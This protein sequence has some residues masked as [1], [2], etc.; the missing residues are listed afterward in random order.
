MTERAAVTVNAHIKFRN[1]QV[2]PGVAKQSIA[3]SR[4]VDC[5]RFLVFIKIYLPPQ[6]DQ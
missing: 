3:T 2:T 4:F 1:I 6:Y 5:G